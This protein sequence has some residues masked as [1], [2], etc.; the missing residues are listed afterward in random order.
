MPAKLKTKPVGEKRVPKG[1][2]A[3]TPRK[4]VTA[5]ERV[6]GKRAGQMMMS[7]AAPTTSSAQF[8]LWKAE[9]K[10]AVLKSNMPAIPFAPF[11]RLCKELIQK[12]SGSYGPLRA[13]KETIQ[14]LLEASE[15]FLTSTLEGVHLLAVHAGR[16]TIMRKDFQTLYRVAGT[17]KSTHNQALW[18]MID[19]SS[20][21][22]FPVFNQVLLEQ[23]R[24]QAAALAST[25]AVE[26]GK[27]KAA[28]QVKKTARKTLPGSQLTIKREDQD[29][30][31]AIKSEHESSDEDGH[32]TQDEVDK[33][34]QG[35][36]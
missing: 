8:N 17:M 7:K 31:M 33:Q 27:T 26:D 22:S 9:F 12:R 32:V 2:A 35:G 30:A 11:A 19:Q 24:Q 15:P 13:Q 14:A 29:E 23:Q 36:A 25:Q 6:K 3:K 21:K 20:V 5:R 10:K 34:L 18:S 16:K 28:G 4:N 1:I